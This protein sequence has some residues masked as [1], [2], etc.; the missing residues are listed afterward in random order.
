MRRDNNPPEN[1]RP[2][3]LPRAR[4]P[5]NI[6]TLLLVF[7]IVITYT[8]V[9]ARGIFAHNNHDGHVGEN[10]DSLAEK[11]HAV[12]TRRDVLEKQYDNLAKSASSSLKENPTYQDNQRKIETLFSET[13]STIE[14]DS[15]KIKL[16]GMLLH[17]LEVSKK[18]AHAFEHADCQYDEQAHLVIQ[19]TQ[20]L[21]E[22][23][24]KCSE[25]MSSNKI[26]GIKDAI[27]RLENTLAQFELTTQGVLQRCAMRA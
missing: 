16:A 13:K 3:N 18:N 1:A 8:L 14:L 22:V 21:Y 25:M 10:P 24:K 6:R 7:G 19:A 26:N 23:V 9:V 11:M 5:A 20:Q 15:E 27:Q 17:A 4:V 12:K 2:N